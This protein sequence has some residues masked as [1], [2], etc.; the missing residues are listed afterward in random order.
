MIIFFWHN[1]VFLAVRQK[2]LLQGKKVLEKEN[3][4]RKRFLASGIISV[5]FKDERERRA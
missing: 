4:S 1:N 3:L 2:L 5:E